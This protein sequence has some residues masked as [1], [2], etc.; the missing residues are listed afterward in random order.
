MSQVDIEKQPKYE[1]RK[2]AE[3]VRWDENPRTITDKEYERLQEHIRHLGVYKPLL[4][5]Q[6]NIVLGGNQR[7]KALIDLG[8]EEVMCSVVTTK[9]KHQMIEYALSDNDQMGKFDEQ[10]VAELVTLNPIK[11]ELF[12]LNTGSLK[13]VQTVLDE[14]GPSEGEQAQP[15]ELRC[16]QCPIHCGMDNM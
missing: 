2:T 13:P 10:K 11:T 9:D 12:K 8:H 15:G 5:N 14:H 6:D 3:L 16:R 7:L 1:V 4:I